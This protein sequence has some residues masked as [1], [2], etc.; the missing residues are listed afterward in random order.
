MVVSGD[1]RKLNDLGISMTCKST[2]YQ[3]NDDFFLISP[4][5]NGGVATFEL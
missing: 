4:S 2:F 1:Y 3:S 5:K